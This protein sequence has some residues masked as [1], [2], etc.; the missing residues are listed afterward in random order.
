M[1]YQYQRQSMARIRQNMVKLGLFQK[2]LVPP[3]K[4]EI[5][6]RNSVILQHFLEKFGSKKYY[7]EFNKIT[8]QEKNSLYNS[9]QNTRCEKTI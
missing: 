7:A 2:D 5:F 6:E 8:E 9:L 3:R 4:K 1:S